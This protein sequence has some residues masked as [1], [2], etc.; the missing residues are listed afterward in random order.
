MAGSNCLGISCPIIIPKGDR[1]LPGANGNN[2]NDGVALLF[3][4]CDTTHTTST[5]G[6]EQALETQVVATNVVGSKDKLVGQALLVIP[7]TPTDDITINIKV[8]NQTIFTKT[9]IG[10]SS[11]IPIPD[12]DIAASYMLIDFNILAKSDGTQTKLCKATILGN[13]DV[14]DSTAYGVLSQDFTFATTFTVN[15]TVATGTPQTTVTCMFFTLEHYK[16][17]V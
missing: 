8:G 11:R 5:P 6:S 17:I 10:N 13:P 12:P 9:I 16:I 2:G 3:N 14:S 4:T 1:G 7:T 15:V